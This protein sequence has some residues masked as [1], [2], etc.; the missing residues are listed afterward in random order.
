MIHVC[1][2]LNIY[3]DCNIE[4]QIILPAVVPGEEGRMIY[5]R[6]SKLV[7]ENYSKSEL[8]KVNQNISLQI[9]MVVWT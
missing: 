5:K 3:H 8:I 6:M 1:S 9:R 2:P 4:S 7:R